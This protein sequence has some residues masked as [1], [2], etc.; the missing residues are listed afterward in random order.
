MAGGPWRYCYLQGCLHWSTCRPIQIWLFAWACH[1]GAEHE[2]NTCQYVKIRAVRKAGQPGGLANSWQPSLSKVSELTSQQACLNKTHAMHASVKTRQG[3]RV[4]YYSVLC[5]SHLSHGNNICLK[6][7]SCDM[8]G[9]H[10]YVFAL[11]FTMKWVLMQHIG[12]NKTCISDCNSQGLC[13]WRCFD[14]I[15]KTCFC[16]VQGSHS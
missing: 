14:V 9:N 1:A 16:I 10:G 5:L 6:S 8:E 11:H 15:H 4:S 3:A 2:Q 13:A 12:N 7:G